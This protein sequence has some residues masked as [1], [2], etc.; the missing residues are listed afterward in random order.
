MAA[1]STSTSRVF[2]QSFD[3]FQLNTVQRH[4]VRSRE[5]QQLRG[6]PQRRRHRQCG[7]DRRLH[8][9][10]A[11]GRSLAAASKSSSSPGRCATSLSILGGI[12]AD[13]RYR[14]NLVG[15]ERRC[16]DLGALFQLPGRRLSNSAA[17]TA[18]GSIGW[19]PPI[20]GS[21]LRGLVYVDARHSSEFNTGSDLDREKIQ[22]GYTVFNG[23]IGLRGP[24]QRW[25]VEL[26]AQNMFDKNYKQVAFD[27][28][29]QGIGD[30]PRRRARLLSALDPIVRR[31]PGR[32]A[33][34]RADGTRQVRAPSAPRR[35][36]M[37][38]RRRRRRRRQRRP[39]PTDR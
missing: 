33:H 11:A 15:A 35:P 39:A 10:D 2:R 5:R 36:N 30:R 6:R 7:V 21:G 14:N 37:S 17:F 26:W 8:R 23:R 27:A 32:A 34:L 25:A 38:R 13:T 4:R 18:T 31:L 3:D 28:P 12:Y 1:G 16:A 29:L 22:E 24:D 9:Q 19:T 20:G